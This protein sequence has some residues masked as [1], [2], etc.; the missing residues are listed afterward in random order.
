MTILLINPTASLKKEIQRFYPESYMM[1]DA[2]ALEAYHAVQDPFTDDVTV[3]HRSGKCKTTLT[4]NK[5]E[6][7]K[8]IVRT[9][10][11]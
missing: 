3:F 2:L 6:C 10:G 5:S 9:G 7:L 4:F 11:V 8:I 1:G